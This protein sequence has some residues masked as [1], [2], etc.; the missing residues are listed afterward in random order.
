MSYM[1]VDITTAADGP[2]QLSALFAPGATITGVTITPSAAAVDPSPGLPAPP[3]RIAKRLVLQG[4]PGN[5]T[6]LAYVGTDASLLPTSGGG[7]GNSLRAGDV[8]VLEDV[9]LTGIWLSASADATK[10]NVIAQGGFQ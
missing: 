6:K 3:P 5:I 1:T 8:L 2:F 10:I 9:A 7:I 4:D